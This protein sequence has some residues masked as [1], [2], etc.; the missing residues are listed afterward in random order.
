MFGCFDGDS[1]L[2]LFPKRFSAS[3]DGDLLRLEFLDGEKRFR[4]GSTPRNAAEVSVDVTLDERA[5]LVNNARF[6]DATVAW[7][8][9]I[10]SC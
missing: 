2:L 6:D 1:S 5:G 7:G 9:A 8:F 10:C 4:L 3:G